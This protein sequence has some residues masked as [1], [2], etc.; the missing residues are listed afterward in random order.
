MNSRRFKRDQSTNPNLNPIWSAMETDGSVTQAS[1]ANVS[2]RQQHMRNSRVLLSD[3]SNRAAVV[4]QRLQDGR[5]PHSFSL[6]PFASSS[7]AL[8]ES[9]KE[10]EREAGPVTVSEALVYGITLGTHDTLL[11]QRS[12]QPSSKQISVQPSSQQA[13]SGASVGLTK[14]HIH[15]NIT[16]R[17]LNSVDYT[18]ISTP[19]NSLTNAPGLEE[20][21]G[22]RFGTGVNGTDYPA[23]RSISNSTAGKTEFM[24]DSTINSVPTM[25]ARRSTEQYNQSTIEVSL[26][27][28]TPPSKISRSNSIS[29]SLYHSLT[30]SLIHYP[31][32]KFSTFFV[33]ND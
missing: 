16:A 3:D 21:I 20:Y 11:T 1:R 31:P 10:K 29:L 4:D 13:Q 28:P 30:L 25:L 6:S 15:A 23:S 32:S 14:G 22:N 27:A 19:I 18:Q 5:T 9:E 7:T 12:E 33:I 17:H 2:T 26:S 24:G 8:T